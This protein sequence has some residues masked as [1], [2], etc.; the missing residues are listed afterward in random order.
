MT[1]KIG[2]YRCKTDNGTQWR[3]R[4]FG[5]Y[6]PNTGRPKRYSKTFALKKA[7]EKFQKQKEKELDQGTPR[8][9]SSVTLKEYAEQWLQDKTQNDNLRPATV[10]LYRQTLDRLYNYFGAER[11]LRTIDRE[12]AK[13]FRAKLQLLSSRKRELT[14]WTRHRILRNCKTLFREAVMDGKIIKSPFK[15]ISRGL[16][17]VPSE[18]YHLKPDEYQKLLDFTPKLHDKVLYALCYT[19]G[20]RLSEALALC[21]A[22]VDFDKSRVRIVNRAASETVPPFYVKDTDSRTV[23]LPKHTLDLLLQLHET[24]PER[25]PYVVLTKERYERILAKWKECRKIGREWRNSYM[26]NNTQRGFQKRL[27]LAEIETSGKKLTIHTLRKCCG[28]N[29]ADS[30]PNPG[31]V[32]KLMGHSSL[33]TTMKFYNQVND[34]DQEK[35]AKV[36]DDLLNEAEKAGAEKT[37]LFLTFSGD[38]GPNQD[39]G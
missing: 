10:Q 23:P 37:D 5:K 8:D 26:A 38:S 20:L 25:V 12:A 13:S 4:W 16:K 27:R 21:W 11:L 35:A 36:V 29:W 3:V 22:D 32:Q 6:D 9:P 14:Q 7:A 31:V 18:W 39:V 17:L 24:A 28:K 2:L 15:D 34:D 30:T 33:D 1:K 19:A